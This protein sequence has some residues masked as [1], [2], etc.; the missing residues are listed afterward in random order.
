V[1]FL[2]KAKRPEI[3]GPVSPARV[4]FTACDGVRCQRVCRPHDIL[5]LVVKPKRIK[6]PLAIFQGQITC[7]TEKVAFAE[8]ICLTF[9]YAT[10]AELAAAVS[11][12]VANPPPAASLAKN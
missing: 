3:T 1:L 11:M 7:G 9:D 8:E 10:P 2:F 12:A 6:H 4:F 5:T